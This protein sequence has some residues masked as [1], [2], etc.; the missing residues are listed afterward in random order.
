MRKGIKQA[1][2]LTKDIDVGDYV[3]SV[4]WSIN[5]G[6]L[7]PYKEGR[8]CLAGEKVDLF[9][10]LAR[11]MESCCPRELVP[12]DFTSITN[13]DGESRTKSLEFFRKIL[14][15]AEAVSTPLLEAEAARGNA[16]PLYLCWLV[17]GMPRLAAILAEGEWIE[18]FSYHVRVRECLESGD[19]SIILKMGCKVVAPLINA[20]F[21]LDE[22]FRSAASRCLQNLTDVAAVDRL[23]TLWMESNDTRLE[24]LIKSNRYIASGPKSVRIASALLNHDFLVA[25]DVDA[26]SVSDLISWLNKGDHQI[27]STARRALLMLKDRGAINSLVSQWASMRSAE[28]DE[29]VTTAGYIATEPLSVKVL[30]A[31]RIEQYEAFTETPVD[32][33]H[34]LL[35]ALSDEDQRIVHRASECL[36]RLVQDAS[37]AE[38]LCSLAMRLGDPRGLEIATSHGLFPQDLKDRALYFFLTEQWTDYEACDFDLSILR[39]WFEHGGRGLRTRIA[40]TARRAGRLEL[41]EL[42]SGSRHRRKMGEMTS[43]EWE[44]AISILREQRDWGTIWRMVATAP[45]VWAVAALTELERVG[46]QPETSEQKKGFSEL[47]ACGRR[48][49]DDPPTIGMDN[50]PVY[51]FTAHTR[52]VSALVVSS[53]FNRSLATGSWDGTVGVWDMRDGSLTTSLRAYTHPVSSIVA[54]TDGSYLFAAS[55]AHSTVVGWAMPEGKPVFSLLGHKKGVACIGISPDGRLLAAGGY[56]N[57]VYLWRL[58]DQRLIGVLRGH[59]AAV[60]SVAF[61]PDALLLATGAED[62]EV[63][64]WDVPSQRLLNVLKG[65][66]LTVRSVCFN[67]DGTKVVSGSSDNDVIIWDVSRTTLMYR[68]QGHGDVVSA[69]A[70]S[71]DGRVIASA[72]WDEQVVLWEARSGKPLSSLTGHVGP[73]TCLATDVESRALVSGGH[74]AR[75]FV[76]YFQSGIFRRSTRRDEMETVEAMLRACDDGAK[77]WLEFLLAQMRWRWRF[78]IEISESPIL[79]IGEFDIEI[80]E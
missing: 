2:Q 23:C 38:V 41:V 15:S 7:I 39:Q 56:D 22:P 4:Y 20:A 70:I 71:G 28:L 57:F 29:I 26:T 24:K 72:G 6:V 66:R 58:S 16:A 77:P 40:E 68:L 76:W 34:P 50:R 62:G 46:W 44:T 79:E 64:V 5:K 59:F 51:Q 63:R 80:E 21:I 54:T 13:L 9:G 17:S 78:D 35:M 52:R 36:S 8:T 43:R 19:T 31:L 49:K 14:V 32:L 61:S 11:V 48:C 55:G 74:D 53:Y 67:P 37:A 3:S 45:A 60:R 1:L 47:T 42:V 27:K 65:H 18:G 33:I 69:V 73:V 25:S 75:V 30:S 10:P 12:D